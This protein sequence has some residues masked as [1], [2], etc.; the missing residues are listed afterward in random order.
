MVNRNDNK[1]VL[2]KLEWINIL[3]EFGE[4]IYGGW[5]SRYLGSDNLKELDRDLDINCSDKTIKLFKQLHKSQLC[6]D[7]TRQYGSK[8]SQC[9]MLMSNIIFDLH[10]NKIIGCDAFYN[11]LL[12]NGLYLTINIIPKSL[13]YIETLLV[14]FSDIRNRY[15]TLIK[16]FQDPSN[17]PK[18]SRNTK[19]YRLLCKPLLMD[20]EGFKI[21]Y[22]YI[23]R[24]KYPCVDIENID[25]ID[26]IDNIENTIFIK[27]G[28]KNICIKCFKK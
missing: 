20:R 4:K 2:D 1:N 18:K 19:Y 21:K 28:E 23:N 12:V 17:V 8:Y 3:T 24:K 25:N 9:K 14:T 11:N 7:L 13:N 27:D 16:P 26:N 22:D 5:L 6:T 15:Y 10:M